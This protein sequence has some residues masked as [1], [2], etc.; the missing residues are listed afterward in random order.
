MSPTD[1]LNAKAISLSEGLTQLPMSMTDKIQACTYLYE[2]FA[3]VKIVSEELG[4][5]VYFVKKY[6]K[7]ARLPI[8]LKQAVD[9]GTIDS[10][11][12]ISLKNALNAI[13]ALAWSPDSDI[14]EEKVLKFA[15]ILSE[16][17]THHED[18]YWLGHLRDNDHKIVGDGY[19]FDDDEYAVI[20]VG[21]EKGI[22]KNDKK[23]TRNEFGKIPDIFK[24][25]LR[26]QP[27]WK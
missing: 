21:D 12:K 8:F 16:K 22:Y 23:M 26:L 27:N 6:V 3:D 4:I 9:D 7:Y 19:S 18:H 14:N 15:K 1:E 13:D 20:V 5:S 25:S 17:K 24:K 11:P 10:N 2:R